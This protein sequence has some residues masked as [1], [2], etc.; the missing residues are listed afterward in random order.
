MFTF[1][2]AWHYLGQIYLGHYW[3]FKSTTENLY[4][5]AKQSGQHSWLMFEIN[6]F[7]ITFNI[8]SVICFC[9][10]ISN[11][12]TEHTMIKTLVEQI[13]EK[14]TWI[15]ERFSIPCQES[16][17][18]MMTGYHER[19]SRP[20]PCYTLSSY[21]E[22]PSSCPSHCPEALWAVGWWRTVDEMTCSLQSRVVHVF[23]TFSQ[24][25]GAGVWCSH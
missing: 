5:N 12:G 7:L 17:D 14:L 16:A 11:F 21:C 1:W 24:S 20:R 8:G 4:F 22:A 23:Y 2:T 18:Q 19:E 13:S 15:N 9:A 25:A 6:L 3:G 10:N